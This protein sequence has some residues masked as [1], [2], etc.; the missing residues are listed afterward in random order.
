MGVTKKR[1]DQIGGGLPGP[2]RPK[3]SADKKSLK[4]TQMIIA[5]L[6]ESGGVDYL[7]EQ[8]RKNPRAFLALLA[9]TLP[10][11]ITGIKDRPL[12]VVIKSFDYKDETILVNNDDGLVID[13]ERNGS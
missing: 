10:L 3:G 1:P 13:D 9:K 8:A 12:Q 11:T 2:G 6:D 5:A 7:V 4:L